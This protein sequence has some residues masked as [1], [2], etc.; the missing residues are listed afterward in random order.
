MISKINNNNAGILIILSVFFIFNG[1]GFSNTKDSSLLTV[2]YESH[3]RLIKDTSDLI[4]KSTIQRINYSSLF[5]ILNTSNELFGMSLGINGHKNNFLSYGSLE[6][7]VEL[8]FNGRSLKNYYDG[9]YNIENFSPEFFERIEI[10]KGSDAAILSPEPNNLYLNIQEIIYN[11]KTPFTRLWYA[12]EGGSFISADGIFSQN[13]SKDWNFTFGFKKIDD[14]LNFDNMSSDYWNLRFILRY[15]IDSTSSLSFSDNFT[16]NLTISNGGSDPLNSFNIYSPINS[17]SY[18]ESIKLRNL[19]HDLN[20][21][22]SKTIGLIEISNTAFLTSDINERA[23]PQFDNN[24]TSGNTA[25]S[26]IQYG[27]RLIVDVNSDVLD[28]KFGSNVSSFSSDGTNFFSSYSGVNWNIFSR[29]EIKLKNNI[30]V[31]GGINYGNDSRSSFI[32]FG[33]KIQYEFDNN[34]H[35]YLD[36]S[37]ISKNGLVHSKGLKNEETNLFILGLQI[38]ELNIEGFY[39]IAKNPIYNKLINAYTTEQ[40]NISDYNA[41]GGNASYNNTLLSGIFDNEDRISFKIQTKLNIILNN[42]EFKNYYPLFTLNAGLNYLL[43]INKSELNLGFRAGL[44]D[45]KVAPRYIPISNS[46]INTTE[47]V[48][49]QTTGL[50]LYSIMKLGNAFVKIEWENVLNS[51]YYFVSYYPERGQIVK[52][53]VA[54]SFFD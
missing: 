4:K 10:L 27:N 2:P 26:E 40:Y 44:L 11:T 33:E 7:N 35:L 46:Y 38:S 29:A 20:L 39:R 34:T 43:M 6:N 51:N 5:D 21:T 13:F 9:K 30:N 31:S 54:W 49:I 23:L 14:R 24:D 32:S 15:N 18:Y 3:G 52:L 16:N 50:N 47:K 48:G 17:T 8:G 19:R 28:L 12:Q 25:N 45:S 22:Y 42:E 1:K 41:L 53:S 37:F 36:H